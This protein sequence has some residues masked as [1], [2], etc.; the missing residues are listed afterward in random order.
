LSSKKIKDFDSVLFRLKKILSTKNIIET[1][2]TLDTPNKNYPLI[3]IVVGKGNLRRILI[4]A[5]IHGDEP[6]GV[7]TILKFFE[8]NYHHK[9]ADTYEFTILPCINPHGYEYGTRENHQKQDLNRLF[10]SEKP[11]EEVEFAQS[12]LNSKFELTL[13]L[14]E[15]NESHGYYLYQKERNQKYEKLGLNILQSIKEIIPINLNNEI[16]GSKAKRGIINNN[17]DLA[18]MDW[19]PMA[20]YGFIKGAEIS[21]TLE[22]P[23]QF[24]ISRRV[25]AHLTA[26]T[27][28]LDN[29]I[30][31]K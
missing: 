5:G 14:H 23:S 1:V 24:K 19:W 13:E 7:E 25:E 21:L 17:Q 11:P 18:N 2:R 30:I 3:K 31:I 6:G 28:A 15:D 10:K 27:T 9:Y 20:L 8:K 4:S 22:A 12:I 29:L 16:D 26:I